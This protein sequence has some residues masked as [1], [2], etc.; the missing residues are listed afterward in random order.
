MPLRQCAENR[1]AHARMQRRIVEYE[2]R[3]VVLEERRITVFGRE[4]GFLVRA[5]CLRIAVDGHDVVVAR[6]KP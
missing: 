4:L 1:A 6:E 3:R 2:T 5:E